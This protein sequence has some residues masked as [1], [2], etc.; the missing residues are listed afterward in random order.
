MY[1][2]NRN[3]ESNQIF[4]NFETQL[5]FGTDAWTKGRGNLQHANKI[6]LTKPQRT[7]DLTLHR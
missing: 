6:E 5:Y 7:V 3:I 1:S 4:W 2:K